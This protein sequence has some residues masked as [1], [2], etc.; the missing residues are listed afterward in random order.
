MSLEDVTINA[1]GF[2]Y[3]GFHSVE[4]QGGANQ[5]AW[6]FNVSTNDPGAASWNIPAGC[7][8]IVLAS[9]YPMV[10]GYVET[11][12]P[13]FDANNHVVKLS[14]KSKSMDYID[15]AAIKETGRFE[16]KTPLQIAQE[17]HTSGAGVSSDTPQKQLP[18]FQIRQ[19]ETAFQSMDRI[20][21]D[22]GGF[23]QGMPDGSIKI[24]KGGMGGRQAGKLVEGENILSGS[25][26]H[27]TEGRFSEV[28]VKGQ[29]SLG[30]GD[31]STRPNGKAVDSEMKRYRP[32]IIVNEGETDRARANE[33]AKVHANRSTGRAQSAEVSIAGWR[34][35]GQ[36]I[37]PN[38]LVFI[39]SPKLRLN[40]DMLIKSVSFSQDFQNGTTAKMS[41]VDPRTLDGKGASGGTA[42]TDA[43]LWSSR[44]PDVSWG[45]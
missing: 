8:A 3:G 38:K 12:N 35:G 27:T 15:S 28:E 40:G 14:G 2:A 11:F 24:T 20:L 44:A 29:S 6:T 9:G 7:P 5:A 31:E 1:G 42:G 26:T 18:W 37:E 30:T 41:L 43:A 22:Q 34:L 4:I 36:I 10:V 13:S 25:A 23:M 39:Q 16:D 21:R 17:L 32:R 33:R 19:G 45:T